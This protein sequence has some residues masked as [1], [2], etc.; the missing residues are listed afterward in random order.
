[1]TSPRPLRGVGVIIFGLGNVG[2]ALI[3]Q[4]SAARAYHAQ[5]YGYAFEIIG[6]CDSSAAVAATPHPH[7]QDHGINDEDIKHILTEKT[8]KK[9]LSTLTS[10]TLRVFPS[11][12]ALITSCASLSTSRP[13][14]AVDCSAAEDTAEALIEAIQAG[15]GVTMANKKPL[16]SIQ[17]HFDTLASVQNRGR[18]RYE[19]T[20]GAATP[21][22][23]AV[24][25]I[26][27]SNDTIESIKGTFSGTL[28][29]VMSHL[30]NGEPF[31]AIV[32]RAL[33]LGYTEP[34]PRD[35]LSGYDVA[36]KALILSRTIGWK[37]E[38]T[39]VTIE[40]L[41]PQSFQS[42]SIAEFM[43]QL[44]ALDA[45]MA[46]RI[47]NAQKNDCVLRYV[48]TVNENECR[49]GLTAVPLDSPLGRLSGTDNMAEIKTRI[50]PKALVIQ[51]SGAGGEITAAGIISD[52]IE[53][54]D[55]LTATNI[56][57]R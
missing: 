43:S 10:S 35:D 50:Y 57:H 31:S 19:S 20:V 26:V 11:S 13:V 32:R 22:V 27:A 53:L 46:K 55:V 48:A 45:E 12:S 21:F 15:F 34:D 8:A 28:G 24:N 16:S 33:E 5:R 36:R 38:W 30:Q 4:L 23:A 6:L 25:R 42:L 7:T 51:G 39:E 47:S 2:R 54:A 44:D 40:S 41:Y 49:V 52:M 3:A 17:M 9:P 1:M 18:L 14:I 56:H 37:R 29:Y